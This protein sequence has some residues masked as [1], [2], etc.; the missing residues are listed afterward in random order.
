MHVKKV[1]FPFMDLAPLIPAAQSKYPFFPYMS[2]V[3]HLYRYLF[4][5]AFRAG[6]IFLCIQ[7]QT[8]NPMPFIDPFIRDAQGGQRA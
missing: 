6:Y 8:N 4:S 7:Q 3:M 5:H 1:V 2:D